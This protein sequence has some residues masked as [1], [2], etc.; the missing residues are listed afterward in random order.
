MID[1][2]LYRPPIKIQGIK[3]KLFPYIY[4]TFC[5]IKNDDV[6]TWIE[7]FMGS[8]V[9]AFNIAKLGSNLDKYILCDTN[10][11]IIEFYNYLKK[12][13]ITPDKIR[14]SLRVEGENLLKKGEVHYYDVRKRFNADYHPLDFLFLNRS[15][16]NGNIRFNQSGKFNTPF[17]K[18][19][20]RFS[21]SYITKI[22]N[23]VTN[24]QNIIKNNNFEF[25]CQSYERTLKLKDANNTIVYCDPPYINRNATYYNTWHEYNELLLYE[26]L[27]KLKSKFMLSTWHHDEM[28]SNLYIDKLWNKFNIITFE[29]FYHIAGKV[30][31]R[32]SV[33]EAIVFNSDTTIDK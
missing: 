27:C 3:I 28:R 12:D 22:V 19:I 17:C 11:H 29:H 32:R 21:K 30:E 2:A 14:E 10:P 20:N 6:D 5:K 4:D 9:I 1:T 16:F 33:T 23:Q 18:K 24:I 15:C 26:S 13:I 8:G 7:P 31:N 25:I